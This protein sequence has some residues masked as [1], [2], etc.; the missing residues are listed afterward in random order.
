VTNILAQYKTNSLPSWVQLHNENQLEISTPFVPQTTKFAFAISAQ[1]P[2]ASVSYLK[3]IFL[4]VKQK[5]S[6]KN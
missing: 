6:V 3:P 2:G 4:T 5:C 1:E